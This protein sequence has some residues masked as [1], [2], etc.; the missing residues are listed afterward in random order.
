MGKLRKLALKQGRKDR[1]KAGKR[2]KKTIKY[3]MLSENECTDA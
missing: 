3:D 2:K 1:K